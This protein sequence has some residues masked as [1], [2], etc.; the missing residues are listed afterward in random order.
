MSPAVLA[1][2]VVQILFGLN[3]VASKVVLDYMPPLYWGAAR[4]WCAALVMFALTPFVVPKNRRTID[5]SF[6]KSCLLFGFFGIALNQAFFLLG[7]HYTTPANSSILNTMTPVMTLAIALLAGKERF[8]LIKVLGVTIAFAGVLVLRRFEDFSLSSDTLKGDVFTLLN[9][10]SLALF[11]IMSRTFLKKH[12]TFWVTS[13]MFLFGAILLTFAAVPDYLAGVSR[14][15]TQ[16]EIFAM[17]YN[18]VAATVITYFLNSWALARVHSSS[19]A[20]FIYLQPVI[21]ILFSWVVMHEQPTLRMLLAVLTIFSGLS[22]ALWQNPRTQ[23]SP[24]L[25]EGL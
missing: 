7:L 22:L 23:N 8:S 15:P 1:L 9:C 17:I 24:P 11:F 2:L 16:T 18:V 13:W 3:Y 21:S 10:L 6:L 4:M 25:A 5:A 19:V 20:L 14:A 12:S